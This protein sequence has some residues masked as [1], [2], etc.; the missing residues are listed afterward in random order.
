MRNKL[1]VLAIA[2]LL[3]GAWHLGRVQAQST[4]PFTVI[5]GSL[6]H[7]SCPAVAASTTQFCFANDGLWQSIN[8]AAYVQLTPGTA[9]G[10]TSVTVCNA[11]GASCGSAQTGAVSLNIPTKVTV[12]APTTTVTNTAPTATATT[13]APTATLQ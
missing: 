13:T 4:T 12:T 2:V 3:F 9:G 11:A 6:T 1:V 10:V 8:G 5:A 7:T